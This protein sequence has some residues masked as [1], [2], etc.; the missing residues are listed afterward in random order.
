MQTDRNGG[1]CRNK[2]D[3]YLKAAEFLAQWPTDKV[4]LTALR[5]RRGPIKGE[6]FA[7]TDITG[8]AAWIAARQGEHLNL[9]YSVNDL[10]VD[11]GPGKPK[12]GKNDVSFM[13]ALHVDADCPKTLR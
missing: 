1:S 7:K 3:D 10:K 5:E 6:S 8:M 2:L 13:V 4:H 11:L 9:Y 12:A